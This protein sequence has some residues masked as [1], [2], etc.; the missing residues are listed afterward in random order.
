MLD[1]VCFCFLLFGDIVLVLIGWYELLNVVTSME[2][3]NLCLLDDVTMWLF[4]SEQDLL[5]EARESEEAGNCIVW[6]AV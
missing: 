5:Q 2:F 1:C 6:I 3:V 4:V